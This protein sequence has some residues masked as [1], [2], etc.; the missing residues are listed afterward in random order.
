MKV[1]NLHRCG[2]VYIYIVV[3]RTFP[4]YVYVLMFR[5]FGC[6]MVHHVCMTLKC[7]IGVKGSVTCPR[8]ALVIKELTAGLLLSSLNFHH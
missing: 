8:F 3:I 4:K 7:Q 5:L 1:W 2:D 6:C